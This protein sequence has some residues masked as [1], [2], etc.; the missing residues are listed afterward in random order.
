MICVLPLKPPKSVGGHSCRKANISA[1]TPKTN[2]IFYAVLPFLPAPPIPN[3][4]H[5]IDRPLSV[6]MMIPAPGRMQP[7]FDPSRI[8]WNYNALPTPNQFMNCCVLVMSWVCI[9]QCRAFVRNLRSL[10]GD[11]KRRT[12]WR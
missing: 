7:G 12:L 11:C 4:I 2:A 5:E 10:P 6:A 8:K 3:C 9:N 1:G